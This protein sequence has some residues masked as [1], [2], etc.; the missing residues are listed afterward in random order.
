MV[1]ILNAMVSVSPVMMVELRSLER[2][3]KVMGMTI[4]ARLLLSGVNPFA[5]SYSRTSDFYD[6][7]VT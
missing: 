2:L 1:Y 4:E 6:A 3:L 5:D 7:R